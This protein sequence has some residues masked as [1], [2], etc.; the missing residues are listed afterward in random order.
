MDPWIFW[1][2]GIPLSSAFV[3][4]A[5]SD[6]RQKYVVARDSA[7]ID[8]GLAAFTEVIQSKKSPSDRMG[9]Y[10]KDVSAYLALD[11]TLKANCLAWIQSGK[12]KAYGFTLPR[13]AEDIPQPAPLDLWAGEIKWE[14]DYAKG[15]GL[16]M[17]GL[18]LIAPAQE[19]ELIARHFPEGIKSPGRPSREHQISEAFN[20]LHA[21]GAI[22]FS[23]PMKHY[24][25][26]IREWVLTH[27]PDDP[28][29]TKGLN[30]KTLAKIVSPLF[31]ERKQISKL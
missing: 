14:K 9:K 23:K 10:N 8:K 4:F 15:N 27:F 29:K 17:A 2:R 28:K 26:M 1:K 7:G 22:N 19:A 20:T 3:S 13:R 21:S 12:L 31:N 6:F 18:R 5:S 24:F 30:D 11:R 16:E 25:P